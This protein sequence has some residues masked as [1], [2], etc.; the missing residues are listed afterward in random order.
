MRS[1]DYNILL[2]PARKQAASVRVLTDLAAQ[3]WNAHRAWATELPAKYR[4]LQL[5]AVHKLTFSC[6]PD[7]TDGLTNSFGIRYTYWGSLQCLNLFFPF[8]A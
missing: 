3:N 8:F 6:A 1:G 4:G 7:R 2:R 5:V